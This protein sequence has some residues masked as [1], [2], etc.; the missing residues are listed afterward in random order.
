[1]EGWDGLGY[2]QCTGRESNSQSLYDE[3]DALTTTLPSHSV[4]ELVGLLINKG[5]LIVEGED[6]DIVQAF[7]DGGDQWHDIRLKVKSED[8]RY[9][10][11]WLVP[12]GQQM[13][14]PM[15]NWGQL[16]NPE[17]HGHYNDVC[18]L[19]VLNGVEMCLWWDIADTSTLNSWKK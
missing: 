17:F 3:S 19:C 4:L 13:D 12:G 16:A 6:D 2:W 10:K 15:E 7:Y 18:V 5:G 8:E 14:R 9:E 1:M 11:F